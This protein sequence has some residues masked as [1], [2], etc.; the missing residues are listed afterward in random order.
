MKPESS[1]NRESEVYKAI[2]E[3]EQTQKNFNSKQYDNVH[4][5]VSPT[6]QSHAFRRLQ[7]ALY[8]DQG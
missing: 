3:E 4:G 6:I 8:Q 5:S 7:E 1:V 2:L